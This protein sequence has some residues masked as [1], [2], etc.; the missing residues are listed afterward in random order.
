[1]RKPIRGLYVI[2]DPAACAGR[3]PIATARQAIDGGASAVQ[4]RD[5]HRPPSDQMADAHAVRELCRER[6]VIFIINDYP[7]LARDVDADG[8]HLGQT[9]MPVEQARPIV[10]CQKLIGVSTNSV[11]EAIRAQAAGADYIAVGSIF[12]TS[13]KSRTR[14]ANLDRLH[15]VDMAVHVPVVAIGGIN[16]SNIRGVIDA[17][18]SAV[19][20]I[21]AVCA[22]P[23]PRAAA[24]ELTDAFAAQRRAGNH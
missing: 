22:A 19:A 2:I 21:S 6:G 20:V 1:M 24:R 3:D 18:A 14:P 8:L 16:A 5:K 7:D 13:S 4:W 15:Q 17:G 23:D 12:K 9:D 10:G 11:E